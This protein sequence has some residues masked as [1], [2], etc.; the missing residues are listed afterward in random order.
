IAIRILEAEHAR[1]RDFDLISEEVGERRFGGGGDLVVLDPIDGSVNAKM[2]IPYFSLT[3]AAGSGRTYGDL[4]EGMVRNLIS[5][6]HFEAARGE[7]AWRD[8]VRIIPIPALEDGRLR[9]LQVEP[10]RLNATYDG[11][12]PLVA[13][14]EKL[15]ML[16]SAALNLAH[17]ATG[18]VS[19]SVAASLRS[20][21][22]AGPV[23]VIEAAGGAVATLA[24]EPIGAIDL[25][26][27]HRISLAAAPD[28]ATLRLVLDLLREGAGPGA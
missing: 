11:Y 28:P 13:R 26:L 14:A 24:G 7:G 3:M 6:E 16:G 5:G 20:V 10:T 18:T 19:A 8:G 25:G 23:V 17:T 22:C 15:R 12:R 21:D 9:L 2:G 4:R 27:D 1:G